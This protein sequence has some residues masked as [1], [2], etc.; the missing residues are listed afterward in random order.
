MA[1][2]RSPTPDFMA[3]GTLCGSGVGPDK[4]V[5]SV[6]SHGFPIPWI[7]ISHG[8]CGFQ[9]HILARMQ[10]LF[11]RHLL[12]RWPSFILC[13]KSAIVSGI[14]VAMMLEDAFSVRLLPVLLA[15]SIDGCIF[16]ELTCSVLT[17]CVD[18][19]LICTNPC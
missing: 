5:L 18:R 15:G 4:L 7:P 12:K 16:S 1:G 10:C 19:N 11:G 3:P 6:F 9:T 2:R 14:M 13:Q 17:I 8:I